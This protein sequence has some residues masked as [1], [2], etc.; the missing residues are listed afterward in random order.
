MK[1]VERD[2]KIC[3]E[4]AEEWE[5]VDVIHGEA[6]DHDLLLEEG[7]S[8]AGAFVALADSDEENILLSVFAKGV[9]CG[10][11]I[12]KIN[13]ID[14][15][16]VINQL[17]LDTT[18][19]PR[20]ITA[21]TILR[22]VRAMKNTRGSNVET[23]CNFIPGKVEASEFTVRENS[24]IVGVPL[25]QLKFKKN[26]LVA[27]ISR[28]NEVIVPRGQDVINAGDAVVIVSGFPLHDIADVLK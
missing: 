7:I 19:C 28:G 25:Y 9:G 15:D 6:S 11:L 22:H 5:N 26:V 17:D 12:T 13:R 23:L 1:V 24:P 20:S 21:D 27:S 4:I 16:N 14:Y 2:R 10:K 8:T 18:V 3:E